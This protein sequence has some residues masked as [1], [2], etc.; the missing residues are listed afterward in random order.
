MTPRTTSLRARIALAALSA[1]AILSACAGSGSTRDRASLV[2]GAASGGAGGSAA[3]GDAATGG[4]AA[5]GN[6]GGGGA[7]GGQP[8]ACAS[9]ADCHAVSDY[10]TG[11]DCRALA[12]GQ[13]LPACPGPGVQ[14]FADPCMNKSAVCVQ[15][16]CRIAPDT[17]SL[18]GESCAS[19]EACCSGLTCCAGVPVPAGS[20][21]CSANCPIS[22]RD[23]KQ[24]FLS[25][26]PDT[27]L[28]GVMSLP[29]SR[30]SYI[31]EGERVTHLGPMAQDFQA[32]F[33]LGESEKTIL[34]VD[35]DGVA[36]AAIQAL[37]RRVE[38]LVA[39]NAALQAKVDDLSRASAAK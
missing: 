2:D 9:D 20:E 16:T 11:C 17:C 28:D 38:K 27:I 32:R 26:D 34:Q 31:A 23:I 8:A 22:D 39:E 30:W 7:G 33:G 21:Y 1:A 4:T 13:T 10:C 29:I 25:V 24:G 12:T 6:A 5:G 18:N 19:G 36:L 14:C 15:G 3:G 35:A 37:N